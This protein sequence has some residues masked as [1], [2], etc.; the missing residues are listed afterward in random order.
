MNENV[1]PFTDEVTIVLV[2]KCSQ[3]LQLLALHSEMLGYILGL[4][5]GF[6]YLQKSGDIIGNNLSRRICEKKIRIGCAI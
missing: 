2:H 3:Q 4:W 6:G 5:K 1:P